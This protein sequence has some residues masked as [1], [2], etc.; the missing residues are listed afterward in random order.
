[1]TKVKTRMTEDLKLQH[2]E[3][4][5]TTQVMTYQVLLTTQV[6]TLD[7]LLTIQVTTLGDL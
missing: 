6:T 4:L 3:D 2:G 5:L 7:D 1:M